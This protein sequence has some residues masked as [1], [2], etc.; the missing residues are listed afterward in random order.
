[1]YR[2]HDY[3]EMFNWLH[4]NDAGNCCLRT[5]KGN[6]WQWTKSSWRLVWLR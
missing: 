5:R 1:M 3:V 6:R 4:A 2:F